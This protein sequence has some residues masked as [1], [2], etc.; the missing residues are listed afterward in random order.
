MPKIIV[1]SLVNGF[2]RAGHAFTRE[3]VVLDTADLSEEQ[4]AAI[5]AEPKLV[6]ADHVEPES[7][8]KTGPKPAEKSASG[9][10]AAK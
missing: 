8:D 2:R 9:G 10:K 1:K 5:K 7:A 6:V 3:G 4:L